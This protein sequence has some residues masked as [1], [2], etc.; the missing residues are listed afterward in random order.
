MR[1][2]TVRTLT[3]SLGLTLALIVS[4]SALARA[5]GGKR[6]LGGIPEKGTKS[7]GHRGPGKTHA[8]GG[9]LSLRVSRSGGSVQVSFTS[10][11]PV[12]YCYTTKQLQVQKSRGARIS[13]SGSF[14]ASVEERFS[15]GPGLPPIV[16][17]VSGRFNGRVATGKIET[18]AAPC[19]GWT[20]FYATAQ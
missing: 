5:I 19:S 18:R 9:L 1:K 11:W 17:V 4:A 3:I 14:T 15:P 2:T 12:L 13:R 16:Q 6:Y 7:E 20:A 8:Y 10:P